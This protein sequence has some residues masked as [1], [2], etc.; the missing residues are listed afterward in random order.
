MAQNELESEKIYVNN[1]ETGHEA[2]RD[3]TG[4]YGTRQVRCEAQWG[5]RQ[6]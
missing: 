6:P 1:G 2:K 4:E 5:A 3:E